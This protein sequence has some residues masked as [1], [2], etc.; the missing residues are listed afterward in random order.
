MMKNTR[1][2][3]FAA[4]CV[5]LLAVSCDNSEDE[6][7]GKQAT[8]D[9]AVDRSKEI[10]GHRF[11][12]LGLPSRLLWAETNV[13]AAKAGDAGDYFA[14][15][16]TEAKNA[17]STANST[18]YGVP[19]EGNLKAS[20]DAATANWGSG[21][22]MPT[23]EEFD[24]LADTSNCKWT[25][26]GEETKKGYRVISKTNGNEIFLPAAGFRYGANTGFA[27]AFGFYW[28]SSPS[29]DDT[30]ARFFYI[31]ASDHYL[32]DNCRYDGRTVRAVAE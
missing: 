27:G 8:D 12:D 21:V 22:R 4:A 9:T 13:G 18:W 6:A 10:N 23:G 11:V 17:Y 16:E 24:E 2:W 28:T 29:S 30:E 25:W 7:N 26:V 5:G 20:E 15:G 3:L 19:H 1:I 14:W 32:S 31:S